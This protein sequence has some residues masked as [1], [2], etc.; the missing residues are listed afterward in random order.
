M[1]AAARSRDAG[2]WFQV[3]GWEGGREAFIALDSV[4]HAGLHETRRRAQDSAM[5]QHGP[6]AATRKRLLS[7]RWSEASPRDDAQRHTGW[8]WFPW[9]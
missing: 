7:S 5:S 6:A 9:P 2:A 8:A 3:G 1:R 4:K